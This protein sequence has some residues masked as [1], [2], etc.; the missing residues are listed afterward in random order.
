MLPVFL[1]ATS[2]VQAQDRS[3]QQGSSI[4]DDSTK[5][6]YG[7]R[8]TRY[9][10]ENDLVNNR[11]TT[12]AVDTTM[13][14]FHAYN[15]INRTFNR[16]VDL[17]N[18]GT[19]L[20][21]VFYA[22]PSQIGTYFGINAYTPYLFLPEEIKYYDTKSPYTSMHYVQ[23][24]L[25][26]Q[27]L[28]VS[29]SRN[30]NP[31]WNF[32]LD[33]R[34]ITAAKQYGYTNREERQI[35]S[36]SVVGYTRWQSK[37]STYHILAHFSHLN[38]Y[39]S[40][41]GGILADLSF[42]Q[43]QEELLRDF[44]NNATS[45]LAPTNGGSP[46]VRSNDSRNNWH[47]YHEY[48]FGNGFQVYHIF[49]RQSQRY[50]Y[51]DLQPLY[52]GFREVR[53]SYFYPDVLLND[54]K[55]MFYWSDIQTSDQMR[56]VGYE[57]KI[58]LKGRLQDWDYRAYLRRRDFNV[59]YTGTYDPS[60]ILNSPY[61][62]T[63]KNQ[64]E[65]FVGLWT[66]YQ[67]PKNIRLIAEGEY[68][69]L[70]K[71]SLF[72]DY[73]LKGTFESPWFRAG[74]LSMLH[75]PTLVQKQM[76]SNH[77]QWDENFKAVGVNQLFGELLLHYKALHLEPSLTLTNLSNYIYFTKDAATQNVKPDQSTPFQVIQ[78]GGTLALHTKVFHAINQIYFT[79]VTTDANVL[80]IPQ[81]FANARWYIEGV[82]FKKALYMQIGLEANYKSDYYADGYAPS[83][84][85]FHVQNEFL[86]R[87]YPL[88]DVF[89]NARVG[90]V[91]L[92]AK[93]AHVNQGLWGEGYFST[94]YHP[95]QKRTFSF[96]VLWPLFD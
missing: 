58:G 8:T 29:H 42:N 39:S 46:L 43:N 41:L 11:D 15:F 14:G 62:P 72:E 36:H 69:L 51:T 55:R 35:D 18:L 13:D 7:P 17:G 47:L 94:P 24:G 82:L 34:R 4:I 52:Q 67:F 44:S 5:Q 78:L 79:Q 68:L 90:R 54:P 30:I 20:R 6:V 2:L 22:P 49:D 64:S 83:I 85:Q 66:Q 71:G 88:V 31:Q 1:L 19:A 60:S 81:V 63:R 87:S 95:G 86:V 84:G 76:Y 89:A 65:T 12:Y 40:D 77:F 26:Q 10:L 70:G 73:K 53:S 56:F 93:M 61:K 25:F 27:L 80:R 37:D 28:E 96:G 16:Y 59:T 3:S 23:G 48:K 45:Q 91:R 9:L 75:S 21:P 38:H 33:Y 50:S 32:G 74:V 57:N 92:F